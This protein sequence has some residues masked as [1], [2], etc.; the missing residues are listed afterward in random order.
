MLNPLISVLI[1]VYGAE[2]HMEK[3]CAS[4]FAQDYDNLQIIFVNDGTKDRSIEILEKLLAGKHAE[5]K[6]KVTILNKENGGVASARNAGLELVRGDYLIQFDPDDCVE[7]HAFDKI[8]EAI[9]RTDSDLIHFD[10]VWHMDNQDE[11][12]RIPEYPDV[13]TALTDM[14]KGLYIWNLWNKCFKFSLYQDITLPSDNMGED[15]VLCVQLLSKCKTIYHIPEVLYH[16]NACNSSSIMHNI[17]TESRQGAI[18]NLYLIYQMFIKDVE[19]S[20]IKDGMFLLCYQIG[21]H[22]MK[23]HITN[24]ND[25][26]EIRNY[27]LTNRLQFKDHREYSISRQMRIKIYVLYQFMKNTLK[28]I[29]AL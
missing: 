8:A 16:Y 4:L 1:P 7:P 22:M 12:V 3:F 23:G 17:T 15:Y 11:T 2:Q 27:I 9:E 28:R 14:V 29:P 25:Y 26:P 21:F 13:Q 19:N 18:R 20:P 5:W 24:I 6:S 10:V